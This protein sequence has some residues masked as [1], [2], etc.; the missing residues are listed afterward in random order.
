MNQSNLL[1]FAVSVSIGTKAAGKL[2][3]IAGNPA[4][5]S[6]RSTRDDVSRVPRR[7]RKAVVNIQVDVDRE[8]CET[9][10]GDGKVP[11]RICVG[12]GSLPRGAFKRNNTV[13]FPSLVG[14]K[15]TSVAPIDGKWRHFICVNREGSSVTNAVVTLASTCGPNSKRTRFDIPAVDLKKRTNWLSGWITLNDLHDSSKAYTTCPRCKGEAHV[16][17]SKC[18]GSGQT[19]LF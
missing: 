1:G 11:C 7:K 9:C 19:D 6:L 3:P 10:H 14:S 12:T 17:C 5:S 15:W 16:P 18:D 8:R 2:Y 13:H 4:V